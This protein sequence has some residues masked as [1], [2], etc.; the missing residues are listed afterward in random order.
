MKQFR[1]QVT[2]CVR[3]ALVTSNR[4][5]HTAASVGQRNSYPTPRTV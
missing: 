5:A 1:Y 3:Y 4:T 2:V